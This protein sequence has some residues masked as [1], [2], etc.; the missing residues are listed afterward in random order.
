MGRERPRFFVNAEKLQ[1][2]QV[3]VGGQQPTTVGTERET[4]RFA[5][6]RKDVLKEGQPPRLAVTLEDRN[7]VVA[8]VG[9]VKPAAAGVHDQLCGL[10]VLREARREGRHRL[11]GREDSLLRIPVEPRE[12]VVEFVKGVA[13]AG[14]RRKA[15]VARPGSGGEAHTG[16]LVGEQARIFDIEPIDDD[17]IHAQIGDEDK[18]VIGREGDA[19]GVR[20]LL[21]TRV[22]AAANVLMEVTTSPE[23]TVRED[24]KNGNAAA[25][26][27]G[28][29]QHAARGI[30]RQV[31]RAVA[32]CRLLVEKLERAAFAF[33]GE[34]AHPAA[35]LPMESIALVDR[36]EKLPRG[37][38]RKKGWVQGFG[39]Q[40]KGGG[41][42]AFGVESEAV[43]PLGSIRS[44]SG[45]GAEVNDAKSDAERKHA[46]L[47]NLR[48]HSGKNEPHSPIAILSYFRTLNSLLA[49]SMHFFRDDQVDLADLVDAPLQNVAHEAREG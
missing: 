46:F 23:P 36:V 27:I 6:P 17:L 10:V 30:Q 39:G 43:N 19:V 38:V 12:G 26:V 41:R 37:M 4:A 34:G 8:A 13:V 44:I 31:A 47:L 14:V 49:G 22:G 29:N 18:T 28:G 45:G 25:A 35:G 5:P 21:A 20:S 1:G 40:T 16:G 48:G 9:G 33:H 11:P 15:E 2:V 42:A 32:T 3:L 7:A 24:G